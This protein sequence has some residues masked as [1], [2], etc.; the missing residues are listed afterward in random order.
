MI[1]QKLDGCSAVTKGKTYRKQL[2]QEGISVLSVDKDSAAWAELAG[3]RCWSTNG[4]RS[5]NL[6]M[7]GPKFYEVY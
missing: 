4:R 2:K 3:M 7:E 1:V 5:S 6:G